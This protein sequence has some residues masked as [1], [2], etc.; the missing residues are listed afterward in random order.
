NAPYKGSAAEVLEQVRRGQAV[1]PAAM[2]RKDVPR[3]LE[4][5]CKKTLAHEVENRYP[6]AGELG[7][8]V[9][10][11]LADE[12]VGAWVEPF[13]LRARRWMRRHR[14]LVTSGFATLA[15]GVIALATGLYFVNAAR[16]RE[17]EARQLAER[18]FKS[19]RDAVKQ[20]Y[21]DVAQNSRLLRKE[22]GT[23]EL[24]HALLG[25][26]KDYYDKF[27]LDYAD[28]PELLA[29]VAEANFQ[30]G[31]ITSEIDPGPKALIFLEHALEIREQLAQADP[32]SVEKARDVAD[33]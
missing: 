13:S 24:R 32:A 33:V 3:A 5:I 27:L 19:E 8:D 29:D 2:I 12:P 17:S 6:S 11:W 10:R 15:V 23:Q 26:A 16:S 30:L 28:D 21:L 9:N 22:P 25:K 18:R 4:A 1:A 31:R 20:F 7:E 14:L